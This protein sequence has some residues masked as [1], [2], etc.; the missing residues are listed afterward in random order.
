MNTGKIQGFFE[1][2]MSE[3]A[4]H[5]PHHSKSQLPDSAPVLRLK[6]V[7]LRLGTRLTLERLLETEKIRLTERKTYLKKL[8]GFR[9]QSK[10]NIL[11]FF[12]LW[13]TFLKMSPFFFLF[14]KRI[15]IPE[16]SIERTKG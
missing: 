14:S 1:K 11:S 8:Y 15:S 7:G 9:A 6:V 13:H 4:Q 10:S 12:S 5:G 16:F 2:A 3:G